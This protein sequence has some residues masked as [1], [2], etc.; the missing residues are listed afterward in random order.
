MTRQGVAVCIFWLVVFLGVSAALVLPIV[1]LCRADEEQGLMP[2][3]EGRCQT[4][5]ALG[6]MWYR[7]VSVYETFL[8]VATYRPKVIPYNTVRAVTLRRGLFSKFIT[9]RYEDA[10]VDFSLTFFPR[11]PEHIFG[12][13]RCRCTGVSALRS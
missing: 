1:L 13:L 8:V 5:L 4:R 2:L 12:L 9:V 3:Y 6:S 10:T 7:R 11:N